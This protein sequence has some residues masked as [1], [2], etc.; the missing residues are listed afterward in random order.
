MIRSF[1]RNTCSR[2]RRPIAQGLAIGGLGLDFKTQTATIY[3]S[4]NE[5]FT[6]STVSFIGRAVA[7][8]L[9]HPAETRNKYLS[10][11][12]FTLT[13]NEL[14]RVAEEATKGTWTVSHKSS[15][16][17]QKTGEEKLARGDYSAF[18]DLLQAYLYGDGGGNAPAELANGL[19]GLEAEDPRT[20][21]SRWL[22]EQ[23]SPA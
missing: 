21:V 2:A 11:A 4:G 1:W 6:S 22:A 5:R 9:Q 16:E 18:R 17:A 23:A 8:I 12:S 20:A 19:L 3:D 14:L 7:S 15:A 10:I 13:Q